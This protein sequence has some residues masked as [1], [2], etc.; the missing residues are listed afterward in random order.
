MWLR[1]MSRL[2]DAVLTTCFVAIVGWSS[3]SRAASLDIEIT[4]I[5]GELRRN[6]LARLAVD[7][8]KQ[9]GLT[10]AE[11]R[12]LHAGAEKAITAA[13]QPFG[14]YR[15]FVTS[16][17]DHGGARWKARYEIN[18]GT[19]LE[20]IESCLDICDLALVMSVN[21]G[22]GGQK[23]NE[24]ALDRLRQVRERAGADILLEVDGGVNEETISRCAAAGAQLF[25]VGSAIFGQP[26][27]GVAVKKLRDLA[28][29]K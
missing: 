27:Y 20:T 6:V 29:Q 17:L 1:R 7:E 11:I 26:D 10:E 14:Y 2:P 25:V 16:E 15:P 24:V 8:R 12:D 3:A 4:G 5:D 18:P 13:L 23:F 19:P 28:L 9:D 22:F 21:A